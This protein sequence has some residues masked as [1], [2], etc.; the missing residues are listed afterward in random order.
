MVELTKLTDM[1]KA[2]NSPL[3]DRAAREIE[4]LEREVYRLQKALGERPT[5][6]MKHK[7]IQ[8]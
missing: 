7:D 6:T 5:I 1:L 4:R 2:Q 3:C 8:T